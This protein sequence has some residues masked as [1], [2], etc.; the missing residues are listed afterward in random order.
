MKIKYKNTEEKF[1][2]TII[3]IKSRGFNPRIH[4]HHPRIYLLIS[5]SRL[6]H[7]TLFAHIYTSFWDENNHKFDIYFLIINFYCSYF[8]NFIF[9]VKRRKKK[10][11]IIINFFFLLSLPLL[12]LLWC[13]EWK[14]NKN[15][16]LT[17]LTVWR[18]MGT[19]KF[20]YCEIFIVYAVD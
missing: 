19:S 2:V 14:M 6:H 3:N 1:L 20:I 15:F 13:C 12:L 10:F 8:F 5:H 4:I 18:E 16:Y 9:L 11:S 7:I 17:L